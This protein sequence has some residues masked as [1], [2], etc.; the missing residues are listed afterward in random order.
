[1]DAATLPIRL[2]FLTSPGLVGVFL[3]RN[4]RGR[5]KR[6]NWE[7]LLQMFLLSLVSYF[8]YGIIY[9]YVYLL[10]FTSPAQAIPKTQPASTAAIATTTAPTTLPDNQTT[11]TG[12]TANPHTSTRQPISILFDTFVDDKSEMPWGIILWATGISV[13]ISVVGSKLDTHKML[14]RLWRTLALSSYSGENDIWAYLFSLKELNAILVRD[15]KTNLAYF[16][17][18]FAFSD[19]GERREIILVNVDV[20][21]NR[22]GELRYHTQLIYLSRHTDDLTIELPPPIEDNSSSNQDPKENIHANK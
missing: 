22:N 6:Q 4:L 12:T 3:Y 15:H 1:M 18:V 11:S 7:I 10:L 21:D 20:H 2:I 9:T 19:E 8:I 5:R 14:P 16:G 17:V 13:I